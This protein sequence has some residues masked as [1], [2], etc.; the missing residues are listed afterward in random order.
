MNEKGI[1]TMGRKKK[2]APPTDGRDASITTDE[3]RPDAAEPEGDTP[4][5]AAAEPASPDVETELAELKDRHL[6]LRA[7]F[8]NFRR[9]TRQDLETARLAAQRAMLES[10]LPVFRSLEQAA[11]AAQADIDAESFREGV[12]LVQKG[13][14]DA[15]GQQGV[16]EISPVGEAFDG[17]VM[18]AVG[19]VPSEDVPEG[20]VVDVFQSGYRVGEHLLHPARVLVSSG[21]PE[22][23]ANTETSDE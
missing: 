6:R 15:L 16:N 14:R 1:A 8:D 4:V 10:F 2:E 20:H 18:E 11:E 21:P 19:L 23:P 12:R 13:L 7:E 9:R 5:E 17:G 3:A 22:T